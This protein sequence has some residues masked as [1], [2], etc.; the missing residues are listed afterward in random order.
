MK[1]NIKY[2]IDEDDLKFAFDLEFNRERSGI[3]DEDDVENMAEMAAED[4]F[5]NHDGWEENWPKDIFI[6]NDSGHLMG[7]CCTQI[8]AHP[9]FS[10]TIKNSPQKDRKMGDKAHNSGSIK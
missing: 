6:Y 5:N 3:L 4:F 1:I 9:V 8:E 10:A 7:V 2:Q